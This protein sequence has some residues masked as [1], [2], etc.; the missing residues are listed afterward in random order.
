MIGS[1]LRLRFESVEESEQTYVS[2][3][4]VMQILKLT[5]AKSNIETQ[6]YYVLGIRWN[7]LAS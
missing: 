6:I 5:E 2:S 7:E 1:F 4:A 3:S